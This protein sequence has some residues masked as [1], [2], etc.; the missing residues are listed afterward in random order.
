MQLD[1]SKKLSEFLRQFLTGFNNV[2]IT[3]LTGTICITIYLSIRLFQLHKVD[4]PIV[5]LTIYEF[6]TQAQ[7]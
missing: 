4:G 1:F 6:I 3:P 7:E 5:W 2:L